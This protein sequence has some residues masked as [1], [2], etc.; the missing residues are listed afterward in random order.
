VFPSARIPI[1][2]GSAALAL[3]ALAG[4]APDGNSDADALDND[5]IAF[6][7]PSR[8]DQAEKSGLL[9]LAAAISEMMS[10]SPIAGAINASIRLIDSVSRNIIAWLEIEADI[11]R[12]I[13]VDTER[14][15]NEFGAIAKL[16][17]GFAAKFDV[18]RERLAFFHAQEVRLLKQEL[19]STVNAFIPE[20]LSSLLDDN[21]AMRARQMEVTLRMRLETAFLEAIERI[22]DLLENEQKMLRLE[23]SK[24]LE[25]SGV[26]GKPAAVLGQSLSLT[27]SLAALSEPAAL[28]VAPHLKELTGE[29]IIADFAPIVE[30][31]TS[32]ASRVF[33]EACSTITEQTKP[34]TFGPIDAAIERISLALTEAQTRPP[35]NAEARVHAIHETISNL[36]LI[37]KASVSELAT[38]NSCGFSVVIG[39]MKVTQ[40][41]ES[42]LPHEVVHP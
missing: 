35:G 2:F 39:D 15:E 5:V 30:E 29:L 16:R 22:R 28:G 19:S 26:I 1:V 24:L 13:S 3:K 42:D 32:E 40:G 41:Q 36:E 12:Q 9:S 11:L 6:Q 21:T 14:A 37:L 38:S 34:L 8:D 33:Q 17:K 27:P 20:A 23:L 25:A 10:L 18:F 7:C 4:P 31:L